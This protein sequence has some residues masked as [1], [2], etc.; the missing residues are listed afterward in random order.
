MNENEKFRSCANAMPR[1]C[2]YTAPII[3]N[4]I[5]Q[6]AAIALRKSIVEEINEAD[7]LNILVD[8]TKDKHGIETL[9]VAFRFVN[10]NHDVGMYLP[11][12]KVEK[13]FNI[14]SQFFFYIVERLVGF[15]AADDQT[16][17]SIFRALLSFFDDAGIIDLLHRLTCQCY[18][19]NFF[20]CDL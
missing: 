13:K 4:D 10:K 20:P 1:N 15:L 2:L 16:A 6:V 12:V 5:I 7:Y 3:Q 11:F 18:D 19:G 14:K 8:G 9:S 17:A